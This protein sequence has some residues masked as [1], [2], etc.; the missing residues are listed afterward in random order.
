[1][2]DYVPMYF[3]PRSPM[4]YSIHTG[5]VAGYQG[6]QEDVVHLVTDIDIIV[7]TKLPFTFT[8]GH[9]EIAFSKFFTDLVDLKNVDIPLMS[10]TYWNDTQED[11]D[12]KRRRQAEFLVHDFLPFECVRAIGVMNA[13]MEVKV[14]QLLAR[15]SCKPAV[16]VARGWYY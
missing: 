14:N 9:A 5:F 15:S 10:A 12:R 3:G 6:T 8:D 7:E 2:A 1:M 13:R 16:S 4:L 11:G